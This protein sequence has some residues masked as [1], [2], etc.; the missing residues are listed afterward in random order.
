MSNADLYRHYHRTA[1]VE[2]LRFFLRVARLSPSLRAIGDALLVDGCRETGGAL[3]RS[4]WYRQLTALQGRWRRE[5]SDRSVP[6][7]AAVQEVA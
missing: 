7:S 2:D 1:P 3:T 6:A 4:E 5:N